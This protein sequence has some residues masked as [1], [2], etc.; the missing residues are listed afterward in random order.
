MSDG[1]EKIW[2]TQAEVEAQVQNIGRPVATT[3]MFVAFGVH[4]LE[5]IAGA[6]PDLFQVRKIGMQVIIPDEV[7]AAYVLKHGEEGR[8]VIDFLRGDVRL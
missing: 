7:E 4:F 2:F 1:K 3:E 8:K 5:S 6:A